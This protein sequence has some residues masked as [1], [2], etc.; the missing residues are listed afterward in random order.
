[1]SSLQQQGGLPHGVDV[2]AVLVDHPGSSSLEEGGHLGFSRDIDAIDVF[3]SHGRKTGMER[4]G[5]QRHIS[6]GESVVER[7]IRGLAKEMCQA[8]LHLLRKE[9]VGAKKD[10]GKNIRN[11]TVHI[12]AEISCKERSWRGEERD[13][14]ECI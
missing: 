5:R 3:S 13:T 4:G 12:R 7:G 1:M 9:R 6:D 10:E 11:K 14:N 2:Q 8:R